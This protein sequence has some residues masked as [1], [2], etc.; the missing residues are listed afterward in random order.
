MGRS[1]YSRNRSPAAGISIAVMG[2]TGAGKSSFIRSLTN[3][4][5]IKVGHTLASC[6][7]PSS[8]KCLVAVN[9]VTLVVSA[10]LTQVPLP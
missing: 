1:E 4:Q 6:T 9:T 10:D 3:T 7:L 8:T 2:M 5:D